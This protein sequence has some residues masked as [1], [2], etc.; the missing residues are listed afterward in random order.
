MFQ[1]SHLSD[2]RTP[3]PFNRGASL[4]SKNLRYISYLHRDIMLDVIITYE[5]KIMEKQILEGT[6]NFVSLDERSRLVRLCASITRDGD[7]AEDLAQETLLEAWRHEHM[8]RDPERRSQ[9]LSGIARNVCLRWMRRHGRDS[10]HLLDVF[11][12]QEHQNTLMNSLENVLVDDFDVEVELERKELVDLLDRAMALLPVETRAV[13]IKRYVEDSPLSAVAAELGTNTS[14]VAMRLQRGKLA[15]RRVLMTEM[16]QEFAPYTAHASS[17]DDWE[18]TPLWCHLCGRYRLRG[19]R[20]PDEGELLLKCPSCNVIS[21]NH[22][23]VLQG[24]KGYKP[25]YTRLVAWCNDY[26]WTGLNN[27]T[28]PCANC[29]RTIPANISLIADLPEWALQKEI[30][31]GWYLRQIDR[32]VSITCPACHSACNTPLEY[33]ALGLPEGRTF[34]RSYPRVRTLPHQQVE[35]DGREAIVTRFESITDHATFTVVSD[36]NTYQILRIYPEGG[37]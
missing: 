23:P 18:E 22:L 29:G 16:Q 6:S 28:V 1:R 25:L 37:I 15:L 14:A 3:A 36:Y 4:S 9:W 24:V 26:Y 7:I 8:L 27:G 34:L 21:T 33:L 32:I 11:Q 30:L 19:K 35:A 2:P 17:A 13:L 20:N 10:I 5:E 12:E 31:P